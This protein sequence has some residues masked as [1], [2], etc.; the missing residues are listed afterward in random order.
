MTSCSGASSG[1]SGSDQKKRKRMLSNRESARRSRMRKQK[2]LDDL[3]G[4]VAQLRKDNSQILTSINI[5]AQL[6]VNIEAENSVLRA[7][8]AELTNRLQ[9]LN[10]IINCINSSVVC[11]FGQFEEPW[12]NSSFPVNQ[13]PIMASADDHT[14]MY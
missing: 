14:Y 10:D 11:G 1:D 2:H 6:F 4:Q 7:Q 9:A 5:T 13:Q 3:N 12:V 8:M